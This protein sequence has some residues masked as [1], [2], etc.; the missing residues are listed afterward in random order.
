VFRLL[1]VAA[2]LALLCSY[3]WADTIRLKNGTSITCDQAVERDDVVE[4]VIGA[5]TYYVPKSAVAGIERGGTFG[6]SIGAGAQAEIARP[7]STATA[8]SP[9]PARPA[10]SKLAPAKPAA[11]GNS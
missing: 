1:V 5:T 3:A 11:R 9:A 7:S 10:T 4:Y 6:I 8:S 2:L